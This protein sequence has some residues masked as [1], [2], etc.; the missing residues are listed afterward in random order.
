VPRRTRGASRRVS[1]ANPLAERAVD[2]CE[3]TRLV[4]AMRAPRPACPGPRRGDDQGCQLSHP[5]TST[6]RRRPFWSP[7]SPEAS[8]G[9]QSPRP[10]RR[11]DRRGRVH[12]RGRHRAHH[13]PA[14]PS[15][16]GAGRRCPPHPRAR[17]RLGLVRV[18]R[19]LILPQPCSTLRELIMEVTQ[20]SEVLDRVRSVE[21][22]AR[23][24]STAHSMHAPSTHGL[25]GRQR[26][27]SVRQTL[28]LWSTRENASIRYRQISAER[29]WS[30]TGNAAAYPIS[31]DGQAVRNVTATRV[32][33]T[34]R[35]TRGL[36]HG[37]A[38]GPSAP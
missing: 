2:L 3:R 8:S 30:R 34:C 16:C 1:L 22:I 23:W 21:R 37:Q 35:P 19:R 31:P 18:P 15:C 9:S 12:R 11:H 27:G 20:C 38:F 33:T 7:R 5:T 4:S 26:H 14:P 29:S 13:S 32:R 6:R 28:T 24:P 25:P 17:S 36:F 10:P